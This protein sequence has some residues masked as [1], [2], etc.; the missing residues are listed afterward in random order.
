MVHNIATTHPTYDQRRA[1]WDLCAVAYEG[2]KA[3][4]AQ[5]TAWLPRLGGMETEDYDNYLQRALYYSVMSRTVK[6]LSG[7]LTF[8]RPDI[9][10]TTESFDEA[11]RTVGS[12]G[13]SLEVVATRLSCEFLKLGRTGI[14]VDSNS[15]GEPHFAVYDALSIVNWRKARIA[16]K[17]QYTLIV[18]KEVVDV[19]DEENEYGLERVTQYRKLFLHQ[20]AAGDPYEY[21]FEVWRAP[22][23]KEKKS[24]VDEYVMVDSGTPTYRSGATLSEIPFQLADSEDTPGGD[25]SKPFLLDMVHISKSHYLNSADLEW[26]R[27]FTALPTAWAAGFDPDK[28]FRIGSTVAW[29]T[30]IPQ[31]SAAYLEFTGA[32]LGHLAKGMKDKEGMMA[33]LGA[34][35]LEETPRHV[36]SEG[37]AQIRQSGEQSVL[38]G[39]GQA[40]SACMTNALRILARWGSQNGTKTVTY[41]LVTDF[42]F[43]TVSSDEMATMMLAVQ[44][45]LMSFHTF[46]S[47]LQRGGVVPDGV[48]EEE[49]LQAIKDGGM[50]LVDTEESESVRDETESD[51]AN[52]GGL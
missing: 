34:R 47:N 39:I 33:V 24:T 31:A 42:N 30:D 21:R 3:V 36:E 35:M 41:K 16:G 4:K 22:T 51:S 19:E 46:F 37:A 10:G 5:T 6:G 14:L 26:G 2:E 23:E 11:L 44:S 29:V 8:K 17:L 32:G 40:L 20:E 18:L 48:S 7:A 43:R 52:T 45:G 27:H 12:G 38:V 50:T 13:E 49:E 9:T 28:S 15:Q 25:V 1:D